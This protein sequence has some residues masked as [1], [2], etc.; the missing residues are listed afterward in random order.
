MFKAGRIVPSAGAAAA[1]SFA[2]GIFVHGWFAEQEH[3]IFII[4][5]VLLR[6]K[7]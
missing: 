2:L 1:L 3:G 4:A 5:L 7:G 6:H